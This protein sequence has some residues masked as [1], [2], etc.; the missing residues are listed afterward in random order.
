MVWFINLFLLAV[1]FGSR[2]SN[3]VDGNLNN[4]SDVFIAPVIFD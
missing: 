4:A 3:L 1:I 2:A